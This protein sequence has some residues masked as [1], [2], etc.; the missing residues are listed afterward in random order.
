M[1]KKNMFDRSPIK[2]KYDK[3]GENTILMEE[4]QR[5]LKRYLELL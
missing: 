1:I 5:E 2:S 3:V 4:N